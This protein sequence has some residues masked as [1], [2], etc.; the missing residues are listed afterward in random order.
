MATLQ[1]TPFNDNDT[2]NNGAFRPRLV[3]TGLDDLIEGLEGH[4]IIQGK[5]G[6]DVIHAGARL[7]D[8]DNDTVFGGAGND[9]IFGG[10]GDGPG[11]FGA[12][13]DLLKGESGNDDLFGQTGN[14]TL[15]G[16][17]DNDR[18]FG[19]RG[20][21]SLLGGNGDD[22]LRGGADSDFLNGGRG[23]DVLEDDEA[24]FPPGNDTL[25]GGEGNDELFSQLGSDRLIGVN[26]KD[27]SAGQFEIDQL[28]SVGNDVRATYV[29]GD[30]LQVYY[31][32]LSSSS[33]GLNDYALI[34]SFNDGLDRIELKGGETYLLRNVSS[35][36]V[37]GSGVGIFRDPTVGP[38]EL[39]A[40]VQGVS[41]SALQINNGAAGALTIIS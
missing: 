10:H 5:E 9:T 25:I 40:V 12:G 16:G 3:G 34:T 11:V 15:D 41:A 26:P 38:D 27:F 13:N 2:F 39:I 22:D 19:D 29:L 28:T 31:D 23:N 14:D 17:N 21:D 1:G 35:L 18:L 4:D 20:F 24:L 33:A 32:D 37:G 36:P 8:T 6:N 7:L 30:T